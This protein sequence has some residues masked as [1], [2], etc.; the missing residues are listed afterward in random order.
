MA[1]PATFTLD[2]PPRIANWRPL[3]Q[4][5]LVIP[6]Q[7]VL[8]IFAIVVQVVW[9]M[10]WLVIV[11]TG[12]LPDGL[13]G[14]IVAYH[15]YNTRVIAYAGFLHSTY[16]P[17]SF[18]TSDVDPGDHPVAVSFE[19]ALEGRNRLTVLLRFIW[20]IPAMIFFYVLYIAASVVWIIAFFA[21]VFTGRWPGGLLNF[22]TGAYRYGTRFEA[23]VTLLTDQYPPFSLD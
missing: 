22:A 7:V 15:R 17:F 11:I 9:L 4:W 6:H 14:I 13:R 12:K 2:A 3:I 8:F 21:V 5:I 23:Y 19:S 18:S 1:Y 20:V 10:A 16:P